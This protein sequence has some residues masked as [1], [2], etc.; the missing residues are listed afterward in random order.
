MF[1]RT[2]FLFVLALVLATGVAVAGEPVRIA[3]FTDAHVH[4][5]NS[6]VESKVMTNYAERLGAFAAAAN[7]WPADVAIE[8]GDFVNGAFVMGPGYGD[9]TRIPGILELGIAS[10][11]GLNTPMHYVLGNHDLYDLS[12]SD[13]LTAVGQ[14]E[15]YYSFDLGGVHFV[16]LDAEYNDPDESDFDHVFMRV[17]CRIPVDEMAWLADDLA[18]TDLPTIV[19]I[20]QPLDAQ[21]DANAGGP[22]VVNNA[23]VRQVLT[24]SGQVIAVFQGHDHGNVYTEIDG[25]HYVTLAA[26]VDHTVPGPA[27]W[28]QVSLDVETR[29]M[30]IEG[31][32]L[33]E[34]YELGF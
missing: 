15:A 5:I 18:Q 24:D 2:R 33:Q 32:G 19:C 23:E 27:T 7:A 3:L 1:H 10:I 26:M 17:K 6:P 31:F 21:F 9:P 29:M 30:S 12:K 13:F 8:L 14:D 22:P 25:I 16:I 11:A 28:S 20:H 4:D 34:S